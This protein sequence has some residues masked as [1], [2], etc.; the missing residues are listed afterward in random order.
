MDNLIEKIKNQQVVEI[1][2]E[3][4][5]EKGYF[6]YKEVI[7]GL[8]ELVQKLPENFFLKA[9]ISSEERID[10]QNSEKFQDT[11]VDTEWDT[12]FIELSK[13]LIWYPEKGDQIIEING[14]SNL[15]K[16]V[17]RNQKD[18]ELT[19]MTKKV[20]DKRII[21]PAIRDLLFYISEGDI[22]LKEVI[23]SMGELETKNILNF[24]VHEEYVFPI[25][26]KMNENIECI[27]VE[28]EID[29]EKLDNYSVEFTAKGRKNYVNNVLGINVENL[30][31]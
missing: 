29:W 10:I 9:Y 19:I 25:Y 1:E 21:S 22:N 26:K 17:Y 11:L 18:S 23:K 5:L 28:S 24:L 15:L 4:F 8:N 12:P 20:Y 14:L 16:A 7:M 6:T 30:M 27:K 2:I 3:E 31:K 13:N